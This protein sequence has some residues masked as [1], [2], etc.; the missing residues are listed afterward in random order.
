M[1]TYDDEIRQA[2]RADFDGGSLIEAGDADDVFRLL[3]SAYP[4]CGSKIDWTRVSD[5]IECADNEG[6]DRSEKFVEFFDEVC[7][8]L[9]LKGPVLYV[10]DS[11]TDFALAASVETMRRVLPVLLEVPQHHYLVGPNARWC[12]CLTMEGDI[13]FGRSAA[14]AL[15]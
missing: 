9:G 2:L 13:D 6:F 7:N 14:P 11:C 12:F 8:R 4:A 5:A 3:A 15:S 10:G 1:S